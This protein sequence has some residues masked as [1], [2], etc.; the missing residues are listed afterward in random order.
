MVVITGF[1]DDYCAW[2]KPLLDDI[3]KYEPEEPVTYVESIPGEGSWGA[4]INRGVARFKHKWDWF[5]LL[6]NDSSCTGPFRE[7]LDKLPKNLLYGKQISQGA[8]ISWIRGWCMVVSKPAWDILGPF[9]ENIKRAT[10]TDVEYSVRAQLKGCKLA[11]VDE[12]PFT[13]SEY[14]P[15][16]KV[17]GLHAIEQENQEYFKKKFKFPKEWKIYE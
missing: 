3:A 17:P 10:F 14:S 1:P 9:D 2:T 4:D 8:G 7:L 5:V 16:Y 15:L 12:L 6:N 13:H 11:A